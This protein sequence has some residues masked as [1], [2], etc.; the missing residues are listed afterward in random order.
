[1]PALLL[2][3]GSSGVQVHE[4][5]EG[6]GAGRVAKRVGGLRL[7]PSSQEGW[8]GPPTDFK[9]GRASPFLVCSCRWCAGCGA[10]AGVTSQGTGHAAG[11]KALRA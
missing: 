2:R 6:R 7:L 4:L 1:M 8:P 5:D 3:T 11:P 9:P 10:A